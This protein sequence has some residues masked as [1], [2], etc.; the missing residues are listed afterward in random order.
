MRVQKIYKWY[1]Y[2][3]W[4]LWLVTLIL[5]FFS[6]SAYDVRIPQLHRFTVSLSRIPLLISLIPVHPVLCI[7]AMVSSV[8]AGRGRETIFHLISFVFTTILVVFLYAYY[9]WLTGI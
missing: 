9:V 2:V 6:G 3:T 4:V 5:I 7:A 8:R 1:C